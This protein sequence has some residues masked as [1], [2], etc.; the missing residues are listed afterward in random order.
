MDWEI[1][2]RR[3][4]EVRER[5]STPDFENTRCVVVGCPHP[6]RASTDDGLDRRFCRKHYDH[7]QRHG[8]HYKASYSMQ[9]IAPY[10]AVAERWLEENAH[11]VYVKNAIERVRGL[12]N[13][14]GPVVEAFRLRGLNP[15]E[16]AWAAWAR[17]RRAEIDPRR[18]VAAW[19]AVE[20]A[21]AHDLQPDSHA[22]YKQVQAAKLV[23]RL[24]SGTHKCWEQPTSSNGSRGYPATRA[25]ELHV[26]PRSRGRVL[27]HIGEDLDGAVELLS[28]HVLN[29]VLRRRY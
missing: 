11:D 24:A 12:Y 26:Y 29:D 21:I 16:R 25:V 1:R 5:A 27:R 8:S 10:R 7:Y 15:R 9:Q 6:P 2:K 23:H 14:A 18:P 3:K 17:L 28:E 19:V 13:R 4:L 20:L 22:E